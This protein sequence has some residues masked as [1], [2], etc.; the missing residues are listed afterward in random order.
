M[1]DLQFNLG[2]ILAIFS[3]LTSLNAIFR[4]AKEIRQPKTELVRMVEDHERIIHTR[5]D[6]IKDNRQR[7]DM[8][9]RCIIDILDAECHGDLVET[10]KM[11]MDFLAD[12]DMKNEGE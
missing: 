7:A 10:K 3:L 12:I 9:I 2:D 11:L 8:A 1:Q 5:K 6:R 4:I